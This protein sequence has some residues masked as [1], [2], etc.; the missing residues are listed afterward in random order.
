MQ[1]VGLMVFGVCLLLLAV[2]FGRTSGP[3]G[4]EPRHEATPPPYGLRAEDC[5]N[6]FSIVA[7][8]P[9]KKEWGVAVA[10]RVLAVGSIVPY[11]KAGVGAIATQ[12]YANVTYGPEGLKLL[13]DGKS[14]KDVVKELTNADKEKDVR[15]LGIVDAKGNPASFTGSK[16]NLWAGEKTGK[17]YACQG[18]LLAGEAVVAD[19]AKA[20]EDAKGPLAWRLMAALEAAQKA[21]GDKRGKQSA[22]ILVVRDKGGYAEMNDRYID[23]R[24]DDHEDPIPELARILSKRIEKR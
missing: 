23:L 12:S 20:F 5:A 9:D 14:A 13:A 18:N 7:Y 3:I 21:G 15:Q 1:R 2:A 11:A 10:S 24:V 8:D 4:D 22:A 17:H 6:T 16:C 19:M